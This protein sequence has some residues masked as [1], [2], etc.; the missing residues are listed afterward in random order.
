[1]ARRLCSGAEIVGVRE[2][3]A[4]LWNKALSTEKRI[5]EVGERVRGCEAHAVRADP[6][7]V[8]LRY[9][10]LLCYWNILKR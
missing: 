2:R 6:S 8:A 4:A 3:Q 9:H 10:I 7:A 1:M 5:A